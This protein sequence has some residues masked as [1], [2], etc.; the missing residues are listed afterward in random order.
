TEDQGIIN[1]AEDFGLR[2]MRG[3]D[4]PALLEEY[5]DAAARDND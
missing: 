3:R 5:L 2:Y 4:F 1:W